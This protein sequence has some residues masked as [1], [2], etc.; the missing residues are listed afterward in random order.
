MGGA[1]P[2]YGSYAFLFMPVD[3]SPRCVSVISELGL[4][5]LSVPALGSLLTEWFY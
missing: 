5:S 2:T 1:W 4:T 3:V